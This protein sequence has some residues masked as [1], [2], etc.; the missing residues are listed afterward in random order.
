MSKYLAI[1]A[2]VLLIA[3]PTFAADYYVLDGGSGAGTSWTDAAGD[4]PSTLVRGN[5]YYVGDG[6]YSGRTFST[7]N[8]GAQYITIRKAT[9]GDHGTDTGWSSAYGDGQ[10]DWGPLVF[11]SDYW[12]F[13]GVVGGGPGSWKTGHGFEVDG[14]HATSAITFTG[15]RSY[16]TISHVD[17]HNYPDGTSRAGMTDYYHNIKG[18]TGVCSNMTFS[19]LWNHHTFGCPWQIQKWDT[20]TIEY[21]Y[22]EKN[23]STAAMHSA[24]IADNGGS[25]NA[26]VRYNVW[27]DVDGSA[28]IDGIEG[29]EQYPSPPVDYQDTWYFYGNVV[30]HSGSYGCTLSA[31]AAAWWDSSN[32]IGARNWYIINN[33]FLNI[34]SGTSS[35]SVYVPYSGNTNINVLNNYYY[36][37]RESSGGAPAYTNYVNIS[38]G[39]ITHDYNYYSNTS[40]TAAHVTSLTNN[41][42]QYNHATYFTWGANCP[43]AVDTTDYLTDR[44]N[45]DYEPAQAFPFAA[46]NT[47]GSLYAA[48]MFGTVR[49]SDG[50]WD[51]GAIE[52]QDGG[53]VC[54]DLDG[55]GYGSPASAYCTKPLLDCDD[56]NSSVNPGAAEVCNW[57]DDDCDNEIDEGCAQTFYVAPDGDDGA[58]GNQSA[59]LATIAHAESVMDSGDTLVIRGGTYVQSI[60]TPHDDVTYRV[61]PGEVVY[62]RGSAGNVCILVDQDRVTIEAIFVKDMESTDV[63]VRLSGADNCVLDDVRAYQCGADG[64]Q[65]VSS[66]NNYLQ[67][68]LAIGIGGTGINIDSSSS[69]NYVLDGNVQQVVT[70]AILVAGSNNVIG[71]VDHGSTIVPSYGAGITITGNSNDVGF[72]TIWGVDAVLGN[73]VANDLSVGGV[74]VSGYYNQVHHNSV[75]NCAVGI[76]MDSPAHRN[77]IYNNTVYLA[78]MAGIRF[79]PHLGGRCYRN[80]I[81]NNIFHSAA[82]LATS[83][84][85]SAIGVDMLSTYCAAPAPM[86]VWLTTSTVPEAWEGSDCDCNNLGTDDNRFWSNIF[87]NSYNTS[88]DVIYRLNDTACENAESCTT[89]ARCVMSISEFEDQTITRKIGGN[90]T[91]DPELGDPMS[92]DYTLDLGSPAIGAGVR[93]WPGQYAVPKWDTPDRGAVEYE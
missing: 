65:L 48:D 28:I 92:G 93:R 11:S 59:P 16:I 68:C 61:Y 50:A 60:N 55:D 36:G 78:W 70:G 24:G 2:I 9:A 20:F 26:T 80:S 89:G 57:Q 35:V 14:N 12:V 42:I 41:A 72:N 13:D 33:S 34:D 7:A 82:R 83:S 71:Q 58:L 6:D 67:D 4:L 44:A 5:V 88:G 86:D 31:L 30:A 17:L 75:G 85:A 40:H 25:D 79:T 47:V 15:A 19:Y 38:G 87:Y 56:L 18:T 3:I 73:Y 77:H 23:K 66:D 51:V 22:I 81:Y 21:C 32:D 84:M 27:L 39:G 76:R 69:G 49:G 10:A 90:T 43:Y 37:V 62:L 74:E 8:S 64:I 46:D 29:A 53:D 52:Y 1:I 63:A 45:D 54:V 91:D